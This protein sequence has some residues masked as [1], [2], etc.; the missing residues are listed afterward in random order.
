[1]SSNTTTIG[2]PPTA[3]WDVLSD[4]WIYPLWVVGATRVRDVDEGFPRVGARIH[5][6]VGVWPMVVDDKTEVLEAWPE[7]LLRLRAHAWPGGAASVEL[8]L[9]DLGDERTEVTI[10]ENVDAGPGTLVPPPV[11]HAL[12]H[13]RNVESLRRLRFV[14]E[15]R[16]QEGRLREAGDLASS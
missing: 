14:V 2:A 13:W 16:F 3:V 7:R 10:R 9:K 1:M 15:G 5:H 6:S 4:G 12:L 11:R 8:E